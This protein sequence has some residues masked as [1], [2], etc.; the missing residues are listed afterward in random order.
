MTEQTSRTGQRQVRQSTTPLEVA[1]VLGG[2][3]LAYRAWQLSRSYFWQDDFLYLAYADTHQLTLE[4]LL[5]DYNGHL[6]PGAFLAAEAVASAAVPRWLSAAAIVLAMTAIAL[7]LSVTV[8]VAIFGKRWGTLLPIV[9]LVYSP[10]W[11]TPTLWWAAALQSLPLQISLL[12]AIWGG[13]V[14]LEGRRRIGLT[15]GI[16]AFAL[17]LAFWEKSLIVPVAALLV[18]TLTYSIRRDQGFARSMVTILRRVWPLAGAWVAMGVAYL[19][20]FLSRV[21]LERQ[22]SSD[23]VSAQDRLQALVFTLTTFLTG[24][25]GGPWR[26]TD[27]IDTMTPSA[28][29]RAVFLAAQL[30]I[31]TMLITLALAGR[32]NWLKA[33]GVTL[34]ILVVDAAAVVLTRLDFLGPR[35]ATDPRFFTDSIVVAAVAVGALMLLRPIP[36]QTGVLKP[37]TSRPRLA[38]GITIFAFLNGALIT[39]Q[40]LTDVAE[41]RPARDWVHEA[42]SSLAKSGGAIVYDGPVPGQIVSEL[43]VDK[44]R[45]STVLS[46]PSLRIAWDASTT[47]LRM[48][49]GLGTLRETFLIDITTDAGSGPIPDCGWPLATGSPQLVTFP[50]VI[51]GSQVLTIGYYNDRPAEIAVTAGGTRQVVRAPEGLH[52]LFLFEVTEADSVHMELLQGGTVCVTQVQA[53]KVWPKQ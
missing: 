20:F 32:R 2:L 36:K 43:F 48:F 10:L 18:L 42:H 31:L 12:G 50:P 29:G 11:V 49:D 28:S 53:G 24:M 21:N 7:W 38:L 25:V 16:G 27:G 1:W 22:V 33:V 51:L 52:T 13:H 44:A 9:V 26:S 19:V 23:G 4:G 8:M 17:G 14:Y 39:Q 40:A 15:V 35:I 30:V 37:I 47:D 46:D 5:R 45:A 3:L 41:R 6:M 34:F